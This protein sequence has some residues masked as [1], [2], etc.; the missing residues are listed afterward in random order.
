MVIQVD[1]SYKDLIIILENG[2]V[3][4]QKVEVIRIVMRMN[5]KENFLDLTMFKAITIREVK[6]FL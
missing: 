2:F 6:V 5:C 3:E 1:D 4:K